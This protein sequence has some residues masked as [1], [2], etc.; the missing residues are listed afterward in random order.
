MNHASNAIYACHESY[1]RYA[2]YESH[3]SLCIH[4]NI[5]QL[6]QYI[7]N[8]KFMLFKLY[9]ASMDVLRSC[10]HSGRVFAA[11]DAIR[12]IYT[13]AQHG[14]GCPCSFILSGIV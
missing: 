7:Q 10:F 2:R 4:I 14:T 8:M 1:A 12:V 9:I 11:G 6:M 13:L 3:Y 5:V